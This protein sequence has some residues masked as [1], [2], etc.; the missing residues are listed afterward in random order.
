MLK[1]NMCLCV[2]SLLDKHVIE[3][4]AAKKINLAWIK[5]LLLEFIEAFP[6]VAKTLL[7]NS[8]MCIYGQRGFET[9]TYSEMWNMYRQHLAHKDRPGDYAFDEEEKARCAKAF[10]S[11]QRWVNTR[12]SSITS[13]QMQR[14]HQ[15]IKGKISEVNHAHNIQS[16]IMCR[17]TYCT[18]RESRCLQ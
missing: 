15:Y 4:K 9:A 13:K 18:S 10:Y 8:D 5:D 16:Y 7:H 3:T 2:Y 1:L 17:M 6:L 14:F 11:A 12:I